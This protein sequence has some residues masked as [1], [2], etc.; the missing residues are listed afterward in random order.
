MPAVDYLR[1]QR[2]RRQFMEQVH[3]ALGEVNVYVSVPRAGPGLVLTNLTG[4]PCCIAR[5]G[6]IDAMP[7]QIEFVGRLY[8]EGPMLAAASKFEQTV[9]TRHKRPRERWS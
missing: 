7:H 3:A 6:M 2:V 9:E 5:A 4:H 1:F 8:G